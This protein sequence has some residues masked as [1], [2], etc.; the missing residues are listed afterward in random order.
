MPLSSSARRIGAF[1]KKRIAEALGLELEPILVLAI[2][3]GIEKIET[4]PIEAGE[5][6]VYY[7]RDGVHYVP[8]IRPEDLTIPKSRTADSRPEPPE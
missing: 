3:K 7:R 8:K 4:V 1:D 6:T 5:S 2:G